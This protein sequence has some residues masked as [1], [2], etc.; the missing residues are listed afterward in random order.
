MVF[1]NFLTI[2]YV[3]TFLGTV[4]VTMLTVQF[5][6]E[7]PVIKKLPTKYLV[8]LVALF[9]ILICS[10]LTNN[11][12]LCGLYLIFI[13]AML[14]TLTCTGGYDFTTKKINHDTKV[15]PPKTIPPEGEPTEIR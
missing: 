7:L 10:M 15:I 14:I 12:S 3:K 2:D 5:L 8:F 11:F 9:N 13:N 4:V 6:K 1:E